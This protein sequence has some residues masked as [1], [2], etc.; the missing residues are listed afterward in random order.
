MDGIK[1]K[2]KNNMFTLNNDYSKY[3][4]TGIQLIKKQAKRT[5]KEL[6]YY[7]INPDVYKD[8]DN[9]ET[10]DRIADILMMCRNKM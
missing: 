4:L 6:F 2:D 9:A 3:R 1:R 10:E 5:A 7:R 8:I